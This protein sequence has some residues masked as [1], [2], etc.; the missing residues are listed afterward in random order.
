MS[1][2]D[3]RWTVLRLATPDPDTQAPLN[4]HAIAYTSPFFL[5]P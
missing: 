2:E 4:N 3:G 1:I 5:E